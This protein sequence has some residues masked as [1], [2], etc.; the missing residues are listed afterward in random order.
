MSKDLNGYNDATNPGSG[1]IA[2]SQRREAMKLVGA[3]ALLAG[4]T[5]PAVLGSEQALAAVPTA[6]TSK[7]PVKSQEAWKVF[8]NEIDEFRAW[9]LSQP[10]AE[11]SMARAQAEYLSIQMPS[12][13]FMYYGGSHTGYP[14]IRT[15]SFFVPLLYTTGFPNPDFVYRFVFLDGA[16]PYRMWGKLGSARLF[17]N[18]QMFSAFFG[19]AEPMIGTQTFSVFDYAD[20]DGSFEILLGPDVPADKGIRLNPAHHG[21]FLA[22]REAIVDW[23]NDT[24]MEIS[25]E[26]LD[27][28]Y[29]P[30]VFDEDEMAERI[31]S[32]ARFMGRRRKT[33]ETNWNVA[34]GD[35]VWHKFKQLPHVEEST[36]KLGANP[37]ARYLYL[38]YD[39]PDDEALVI[40]M[41]VP[42]C[43]YWGTQMMD[44]WMQSLDYSFHQ[45]S[46]NKAQCQPDDDGVLRLVVAHRD[47][48]VPNWIDPVAQAPGVLVYRVYDTKDEVQVPTVKRLKL[49]DVRKELPGTT[50]VVAADQRKQQLKARARR[51]L[52]R[53]GYF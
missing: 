11:S 37:L 15:D 29:D 35:G 7:S 47:P 3:A 43:A 10:F 24:R 50:V 40:E 22:F 48:G 21:M 34:L 49:A 42:D 45:S 27:D 2:D 41:I 6:P 16:R 17:N 46:L 44:M 52:G 53:Y 13:T 20:D 23:G 19:S 5:S 36:N 30:I 28:V 26:L 25:I 18:V 39:F 1:G 4:P 38:P 9:L 32:S 31:L 14:L 33:L 12:M 51:S 8:H